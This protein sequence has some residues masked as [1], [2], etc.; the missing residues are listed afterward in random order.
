MPLHVEM[1][2]TDSFFFKN[3]ILQLNIQQ[4]QNQAE[5]FHLVGYI[6]VYMLTS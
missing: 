3:K 1:I 6:K 4:G 5:I 2:F